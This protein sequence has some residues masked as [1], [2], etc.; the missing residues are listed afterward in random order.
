MKM[1]ELSKPM[2]NLN[3]HNPFM[4]I[5]GSEAGRKFSIKYYCS[6]MMI[7]SEAG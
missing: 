2:L 7:G 3:D 6:P 1:F 5:I 4:L